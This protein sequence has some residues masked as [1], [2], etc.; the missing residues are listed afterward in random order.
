MDGQNGDINGAAVTAAGLT[1]GVDAG[2]L[3]AGKTRHV[4]VSLD[5]IGPPKGNQY[6]LQSDWAYS[7]QLCAGATLPESFSQF[8]LV[9]F[10]PSGTSATSTGETAAATTGSGNGGATAATTGSNGNGGAGG[11]GGSGA[12]GS[13]KAG[14]GGA[15]GGASSGTPGDTA[16]CGCAIPG[17]SEPLSPLGA[18]AAL[19]LLAMTG[20][21][22]N[23]RRA[24]A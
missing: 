22:R 3:A 15:G 20:L 2:T 9:A 8:G 10:D 17:E 1:A 11:S 6:L 19:A 5:V 12:G 21:L 16:G 13:M 14:S 18:P 23:R 24:R 4:V 7:F